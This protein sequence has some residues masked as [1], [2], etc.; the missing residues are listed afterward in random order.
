MIITTSIFIIFL[1]WMI[2]YHVI[3]HEIIMPSI[4]KVFI[5]LYEILTKRDTLHII[6]NSFIRLV[7]SIVLSSIFAITFGIFSGLNRKFSLFLK[8]YITILRTIP[9]VSIVIIL[10]VLLGNQNLAI[11]ITFLMVFPIIYQGTESGILSINKDLVDVY[12]LEKNNFLLSIKYLYLPSIKTHIITSFLQ[13]F[14]LGIK[15]LIM[16]E[17]LTQKNDSIGYSLL[18]AKTYLRYDLVFAWTILL[19][20]LSLTLEYLLYLYQKK[21]ID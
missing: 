15:V 4:S 20:L 6:L 8:P 13:S 5:S 18:L 14:G 1:I 12:H 2:F 3:D 9:I 16:S 19:I 21:I 11:I 17:Y 10:F 7:I